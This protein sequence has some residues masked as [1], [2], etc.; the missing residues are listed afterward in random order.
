MLDNM[1]IGTRVILG[2]A[3]VLILTTSTTL[4]AIYNISM[5][6]DSLDTAI[7]AKHDSTIVML[8]ILVGVVVAIASFVAWFLTRSIVQP[9]NTGLNAVGALVQGNLNKDL[10]SSGHNEI[11]ELLSGIQYMTTKLRGV[12]S[13]VKISADDVAAGSHQLSDTSENLSKDS[14]YLSEQ[15]EQIVSAMTEV[16]QTIMDVAKNAVHASD[17]CKKASDAAITGKKMVDTTAE[18][19]VNIAQT[20]ESAANTIEELGKSSAMIGEIVAVINDIADQTNLLALNAAIEAARAGEQGRGFAVVADEVRKLAERTGQSTKVIAER[21]SGI[22]KAAEESVNAIK[23]GS[24]EVE[25]GVGLAKEASSALDSIVG[26]SAV[27]M[28]MVERIAT[29]TEQ[30]SAAAEQVTRNMANISDITKKAAG[31]AHQIG[32]AS[33]DLYSLTVDLKDNISFFKGTKEEA[34]TMVKKAISYIKEN[35]REKGFAEI[36]NPKGLFTNRD[37]YIFVYDMNGTS[38]A[39]G[40]DIN[41]IGRNEINAKDADNISFVK[42]RIELARTQGRGWQYYKTTNP[43]TKKVEDKAAYIEKYDDFIVGSGAYR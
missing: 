35:G 13:N 19:M 20:I 12:I 28:D 42:D 10:K 3:L 8:L 37:L 15:V 16:S 31:A 41:K 32:T 22:R 4:V 26:V 18:D 14:L 23:R 24:S 43:A 1:K 33:A 36:N 5:I 39:H 17:A 34:E 9:L 40:R 25:K 11:S 7:R 6:Q 29:A 30:Q 27:A 2:F 21:V 38:I